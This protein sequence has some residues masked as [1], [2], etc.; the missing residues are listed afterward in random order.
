MAFQIWLS[1][2]GFVSPMIGLKHAVKS[3]DMEVGAQCGVCTAF[4]SKIIFPGCHCLCGSQVA[5]E[6]IIGD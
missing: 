4:V 6:L 3:V 5:A 2:G 1:K